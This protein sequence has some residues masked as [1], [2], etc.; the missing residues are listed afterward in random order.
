MVR[1]RGDLNDNLTGFVHRSIQGPL[2]EFC[3][4]YACAGIRDNTEAAKKAYGNHYGEYYT[5]NGK[6]AAIPA[7]QFIWAAIKDIQDGNVGFTAKDIR[8]MLVKKINTTP[9]VQKQEWSSHGNGLYYR[10]TTQRALSPIKGGHFDDL[11]ERLAA[12][13]KDRLV[14]AIDNVDIVGSNKPTIGGTTKTR[15]WSDRRGYVDADI[16]T[17]APRTIAKKGFDHPLIETEEMRDSIEGW[18]NGDS[19]N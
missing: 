14:A 3:A 10:M 17:N 1:I 13:M 11:F 15:R 5:K 16:R 19:K 8:D 2:D 7:R 12:K 9:R 4:S 18:T 6:T